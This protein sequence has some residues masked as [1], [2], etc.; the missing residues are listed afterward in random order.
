[1]TGTNS[2]AESAFGCVAR[3]AQNRSGRMA[4]QMC[5][6]PAGF[7]FADVRLCGYHFE[8]A[9]KW[10][11]AT[12]ERK[13]QAELD[14][15][16]AI[17]KAN[18][19][20]SRAAH[21]EELRRERE[22]AAQKIELDRERIHAMEAARSEFSVVYYVQRVSDDLIKIGTS[23]NVTNRLITIRR[24]FGELRLLA[25][26]GGSHRQESTL[27]GRFADL[28]VTPRGE[29][30]RPGLDLLEH[31]VEIRGEHEVAEATGGRSLPPVVDTG[32]MQRTISAMRLVA[33]PAA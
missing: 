17:H 19:R 25:T 27:H 13:L 32:E 8:R 14:R 20:R 10:A 21:R 16:E 5:G 18:I 24:E 15:A 9:E 22:E 11:E 30:F 31:I 12:P 28:R 29:W 23:R 1:M 4:G 6:E 7:K 26:H 3:W 2:M 33:E